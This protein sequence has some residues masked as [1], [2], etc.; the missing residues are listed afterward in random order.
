MSTEEFEYGLAI[1]AKRN[2]RPI[3]KKRNFYLLQGLVFVEMD[4]GKQV[5]L[6]CSRPNKKRTV[7]G[8]SYYRVSSTE[9]RFPCRTIDA[10]IPVHLRQIQIDPKQ[11]SAIRRL[12]SSEMYQ[13]IGTHSRAQ[14]GL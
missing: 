8:A 11:L 12:Y 4:D 5:K 14:R 2:R 10:Q 9:I 7:N 1:L 6:S 3:P 13:Y